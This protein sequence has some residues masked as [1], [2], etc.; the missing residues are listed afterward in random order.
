MTSTYTTSSTFTRTNAEYIA[1]KVVADL[2]GM[3]DY[4]GRPTDSQ[5]WDYYGELAEL[6]VGG[7]VASVEYGFKRS[8][9][10]VVTLYYEV[11]ADGSL[12]DGRSGGVYARASVLDTVWFSFLTYSWKWDSLQ[13]AD[14]RNIEAGLPIKRSYGQAPQ[15]GSGYWVTDRSYSSQGVGTQRRTFRPY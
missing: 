5:I 9:R 11:L 8:D 6:L 3:R 14:Q 2:G 10:R 7:Y 1:S 13:A 4:Y 15:D 12:A